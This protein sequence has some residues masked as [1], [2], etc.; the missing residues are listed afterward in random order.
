MVEVEAPP[1]LPD[2]PSVVVVVVRERVVVRA[3]TP[4]VSS[5]TLTELRGSSTVRW[6]VV[7]DRTTA[8]GFRRS[9]TVVR[10]RTGALE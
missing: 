2:R 8:A 4:P 3:L 6:I 5:R 7:R 10:D 9:T 1:A